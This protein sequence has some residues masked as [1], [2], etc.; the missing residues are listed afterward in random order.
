MEV[1]RSTSHLRSCGSV[2]RAG[3]VNW[4]GEEQRPIKLPPL[5]TFERVYLLTEALA[6]GRRDCNS[7]SC[8]QTEALFLSFSAPC[9]SFLSTTLSTREPLLMTLMNWCEPSQLLQ[10]LAIKKMTMKADKEFMAE[11]KILSNVHHTNLVSLVSLPPDDPFQVICKFLY[12][13]FW[14]CRCCAPTQYAQWMC[15]GL[16][17]MSYKRF[18]ELYNVTGPLMFCLGLDY[19]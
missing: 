4:V 3:P 5:R 14:N 7:W 17:P 12:I 8:W 16:S 10:K 11:L 19:T 1:T 6:C 2:L 18:G 9:L 15:Q 13:E